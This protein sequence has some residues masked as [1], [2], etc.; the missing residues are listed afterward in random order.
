MVRCK[1]NGLQ[2]G[3]YFFLNATPKA[4]QPSMHLE[5]GAAWSLIPALTLQGCD[6]WQ[7]L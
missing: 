2:E 1:K 5:C 3:L 4:P 6:L 7:I